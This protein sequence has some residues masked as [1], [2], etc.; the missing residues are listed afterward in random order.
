MCVGAFIIF[1]P[2]FAV[3]PMNIPSSI[4]VEVILA[5]VGRTQPNYALYLIWIKSPIVVSIS[6]N[7]TGPCVTAVW[8]RYWKRPMLKSPVDNSIPR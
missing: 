4:D 8:Q 1:V 7:Y 6:A 3:F 5:A 2:L